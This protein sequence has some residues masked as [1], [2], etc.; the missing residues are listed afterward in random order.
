MTA[1]DRSRLFWVIAAL[2]LVVAFIQ[3]S[4]F[5]AKTEGLVIADEAEYLLMAQSLR[6]D[7]K[8]PVM[9]KRPWGLP[10]LQAPLIEMN[11]ED[12]AATFDVSPARALS[13]LGLLFAAA[14]AAV[15]AQ[16]VAGRWAGLIAFAVVALHPETAFWSQT[17]LT[18]VPFC[19]L[20]IAAVALWNRDRP[21]ASGLTLA[22]GLVLR[23]AGI[24]FVAAFFFAALLQR[25]RRRLVPFL[26]GWIPPLLILGALDAVFWGKAFQSIL[27]FTRDQA[28]AFVPEWLFDVPDAGLEGPAAE[29]RVLAAPRDWYKRSTLWYVTEMP[30]ILTWSGILLVALYPFVRRKL[31]RRRDTDFALV[32][33]VLY[34][35]MLST[36]QAKEE[37]YLVSSAPL[38]AAVCGVAGVALVQQ[39]TQWRRLS[40][41]VATLG[42]VGVLL[43]FA[44]SSWKI[45]GSRPAS[46]H[47]S[48]VQALPTHYS[49]ERIIG[50]DAPW[51]LAAN[52]QIRGNWGRVW[53]GTRRGLVHAPDLFLDLAGDESSPLYAEAQ[54]ALDS[55][56]C[57]I[58]PRSW[59]YEE[60]HDMWAWLNTHCRVEEVVYDRGRHQ[61]SVLSLRPNERTDTAPAFWELL[62]ADDGS[63]ALARFAGGVELRSLSLSRSALRSTQA[64]LDFVWYLP[65]DLETGALVRARFERR[66]PDSEHPPSSRA[67]D[68]FELLPETGPRRTERLG[69]LVRE[70][71]YLLLRKEPIWVTLEVAPNSWEGGLE[72]EWT[73][74]ETSGDVSVVVPLPE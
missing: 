15:V 16:R 60:N 42:I 52:V 6:N 64:R 40:G 3:R 53:I 73:S 56:D 69:K 51:K 47:G 67:T 31:E 5:L 36:L 71:R 25:N 34:L 43:L 38:V 65:A 50:V 4:T 37:R 17:Y 27:V 14:G 18:D 11:P 61:Y 74:L 19:A 2:V 58:L 68:T 10:L 41:V 9:A 46:P 66:Y 59:S 39:A 12:P 24:I 22:T 49:S 45:Q 26:L 54:R 35:V 70:S 8:P 62:P 55:V 28:A 21:F 7:G 32:A 1:R 48:T 44:R 57:W 29:D 13:I 63:A 33:S 72:R 23:Y 20:A 30:R